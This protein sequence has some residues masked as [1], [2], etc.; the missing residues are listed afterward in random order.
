[1][2]ELAHEIGITEKGIEWQINELK[3]LGYIN[4]VGSKKGGCWQIG[5][6]ITI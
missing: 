6:K 3:Q 2:K 4:R 1:M 5:K